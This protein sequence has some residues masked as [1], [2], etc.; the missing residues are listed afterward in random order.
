[1]STLLLV[2]LTA[3]AGFIWYVLRDG[4]LDS[5]NRS[6]DIARTVAAKLEIIVADDRQVLEKLAAMPEVKNYETGGCEAIFRSFNEFRAQQFERISLVTVNGA[7][8]CERSG[9]AVGRESVIREY[10]WFKNGLRAKDFAIGR[11]FKGYPSGRLIVPLTHPLRNDA[12]ELIGLL[13]LNLD[14]QM[15]RERVF[16][17]L[18]AI[19]GLRAVVVDHNNQFLLHT[20][21]SLIGE[22]PDTSGQEF[23]PI[24]DTA[25]RVY[26]ADKVWRLVG[27]S[28]IA[29]TDWRAFVGVPEKVALA[30]ERR[31]ALIA[32]VAG[33]IILIAFTAPFVWFGRFNVKRDESRRQQVDEL[34]ELQEFLWANIPEGAAFFSEDGVILDANAQLT[35]MLG[36]KREDIIGHKLNEFSADER[37]LERAEVRSKGTHNWTTAFK[38]P[39]GS[40]IEI[41]TK[42]QSFAAGARR[43]YIGVFRDFTDLRQAEARLRKS[44]ELLEQTERVAAIGGWEYD[45]ATNT[46]RWTDQT[47][48]LHEVPADFVPSRASAI[49][50]YT[51]EAQPTLRAAFLKAVESGVPY[52]LQLPFITHTG[53]KLWVRTQGRPVMENGKPA[54][55]VGT[56][57]D[58]TA[59][60]VA[61]TQLNE[62]RAKAEI[63]SK[64]KSSFIAIMSHEIRT[65]LTGILGMA[66]LLLGES[67]S[68]HQKALVERLL[69]SGRVLLD[70]IND[71]LDFSKIEAN[72]LTLDRIPFFPAEIFQSV[73]DV[74][75]PIAKERGLELSFSV[76][77][78]LDQQMLGDPKRLRQ[79]LMNLTGNALKFTET[80]GVTVTA[81]IEPGKPGAETTLFISVVDTGIG[82]S[83]ADQQNLFKPY[84]QAEH[85]GA[86]RIVGTGLGLSICRL[87][88]EAM[89]GQI[90]VVSSEGAGSSFTFSI[91]LQRHDAKAPATQAMA[92]ASA[93]KAL[94]PLN[95]LVAED[96]ETSRYLIEAMLERKGHT[97]HAVENGAL[98]V[99]AVKAGQFDIILMD[100]QMP[101][102]DGKDA[103]RAIRNLGGAFM[104][105]PII[106]LTADMVDENRSTYFDAGVNA[107]VGKPVD[108]AALDA[109]IRLQ[110]GDAEDTH[111]SGR[112]PDDAPPAQIDYAALEAVADLL[113]AE[114]FKNLLDTFRENLLQYQ[115]NLHTQAGSD[116]LRQL[117][118][119]AHSI[120][121]LA[122]QFGAMTVGRMAAAMETDI[123]DVAGIKALL[124]AFDSAVKAALAELDQPGLMQRIAAAKAA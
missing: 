88:V 44:E 14:L 96:N 115:T 105:L 38:R 33:V 47:R 18:P 112:G 11:V 36:R 94:P 7:L 60:H 22:T 90:T 102:M 63:A 93:E 69:R 100:M 120:K 28:P 111:F 114:K 116:D 45:I 49:S 37:D 17:S 39:D 32:I 15:A 92:Q 80:G 12:G 58:I 106:A 50:F 75:E 86:T 110:L 73:Q 121:G 107:I 122:L 21:A 87:L 64:A 98:A 82:I 10:E 29:G 3:E 25:A 65:P 76:G 43:L 91:K 56:F 89:G 99:E 101:V 57:Q 1:M 26:G 35:A 42:V 20:N 4:L 103:V 68:Q 24:N 46:S 84:V 48:R 95:I 104:D 40:Q 78:G 5:V 74:L 53:R 70:L 108:W 62:A 61:E 54:R 81:D 123:P 124:P 113:G 79:V 13:V 66:D 31:T 16:Q 55:I 8:V 6:R 30:N 109:E 2:L 23:I 77:D 59:Q 97:V 72:K 83:A 119:T 41:E 67:L 85:S 27:I 34:T 51:P 71:V 9:V 118:R 52:D 19:E 117:R